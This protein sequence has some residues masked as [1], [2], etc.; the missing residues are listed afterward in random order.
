[1]TT[2][3]HKA[4]LITGGARRIGACIAR[5]LHGAG[6]N[7]ALHCRRSQSDARALADELNAARRDSACVLAADL[8]DAA[9]VRELARAAC[10]RWRR[11]DAL[12]NNASVFFETPLAA[13][14][15]ARMDELIGVNLK[16]PLL[17][18]GE[19]AQELARREG[20]I[21]NLTD[22]Y[23]SQPLKNHAA[24]CATQAALAMLT[25][26]LALELAPR[27]RCNAVAPGAILWP[28]DG[29][30]GDDDARRRAVLRRT[31]LA[32]T[33]EPADVAETVLFLVTSAAYITGETIAVDGG[34]A[35]A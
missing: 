17:L 25:R 15:D 1:M 34:R 31:A 35:P 2:D 33:G 29:G 26:S 22:F 9:A 21:V 18:A 27:V 7:V 10:A 20:C 4:A 8:R 14:D 19:L 3:N 11:L 6:F 13:A 28:E 30:A 23:A 5:A 12:V 24:Y 32:R 16:A